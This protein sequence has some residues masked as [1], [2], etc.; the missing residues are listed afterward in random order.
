MAL[1]EE[2]KILPDG[3]GVTPMRKFLAAE[4][5]KEFYSLQSRFASIQ[6]QN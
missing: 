1:R 5:P 2:G 3:D 6:L 4:S